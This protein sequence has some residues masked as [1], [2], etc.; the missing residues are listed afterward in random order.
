MLDIASGSIHNVDDLA[1]DAICLYND[2]P[3]KATL[4]KV[5]NEKHPKEKATE[6]QSLLQDLE[7]LINQGKLFSPDNFA[8]ALPSPSPQETIPLKALCLN[9]SHSCNMYCTYCFANYTDSKISE[10]SLMS[11][12]TAKR[13]IDFLLENCGNIKTLDI[14]FFGGEPLLNW[15]TV[16]ETVLYA[17]SLEQKSDKNIRFTLTTNGLLIDDDVINFTNKHMHNV[18]LSLDGRPK[19]H[20]ENRKLL[21]NHKSCY[22]EI[23]PKFKEMVD[24]RHGNGYYIR[25]TYTRGNLDFINDI[26]HI[27]DL[28]F[29]EISL[30][31][32]V[33]MPDSK[34]ELKA[35]D[36]PAIFDQYEALAVEMLR[37][38]ALSAG[39][40]FYHFNLDLKHGPCIHKRVAGCGVATSY[41]AVTPT[42]ELYPCHQF[43][44][45]EKF[46]MGDIWQGVTN[47]KLHDEFSSCSI[48][49]RSE[50][51]DCWARFYCS[52]G[53][54]ANAH[55]AGNGI[56]GIFEIG[57]EMFKKR[58]ECAIM[59]QVDR[60]I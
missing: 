38:E 4:A 18:V 24:A 33:S 46:K 41:L 49:S 20:D 45:D 29:K 32:V 7:S 35:D 8:T 44:G 57:C 50:C 30:E 47:K 31:P 13:A 1:F 60:M 52:G 11:L 55:Y 51:R 23:L 6:I 56:N 58:I 14:D 40:S 37:R 36:L 34:Y 48:Y 53:C 10:N 43:V 9:V 42:G 59:M 19:V 17:R 28:G 3:N 16:K 27:A 25:G 21:G 26:L 54:V 39:F 5:L 12:E 2:Y 22:S 15:N